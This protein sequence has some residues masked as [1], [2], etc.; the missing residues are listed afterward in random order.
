MAM[1]DELCMDTPHDVLCV[2]DTDNA[3]ESDECTCKF[4]A[5]VRADERRV[6]R[7]EI[8]GLIERTR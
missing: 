3:R 1:E 7:S 8:V 4:I 5:T 6:Y 2:W